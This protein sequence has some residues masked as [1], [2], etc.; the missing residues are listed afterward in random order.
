[1]LD[2]TASPHPRLGPEAPKPWGPWKTILFADP[3]S[4]GLNQVDQKKKTVYW[5]FSSKWLSADGTHF[6]LVFTGRKEND[7]WNVLRGVFILK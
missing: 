3:W 4:I 2:Q 5:N 1:M 6:S 7:S